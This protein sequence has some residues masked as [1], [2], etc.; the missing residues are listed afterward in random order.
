MHH[1][2]CGRFFEQVGG[3]RKMLQKGPELTKPVSALITQIPLLS[4][5]HISEEKL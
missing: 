5:D 3:G 2:R 4:F 1:A